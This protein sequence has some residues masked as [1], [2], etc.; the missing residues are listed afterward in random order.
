MPDIRSFFGGG[1][2]VSKA[3]DSPAKGKKSP[4]PA[5]KK[6]KRRSGSPGRSPAGGAKRQRCSDGAATKS[7]SENKQSADNDASARE[8]YVWE[9]ESTSGFNAFTAKHSEAIERT[10]SAG[11]KK[12]KLE[13]A[14][15]DR[16]VVNVKR[17]RRIVLSTGEATSVRRIPQSQSVQSGAG[18]KRR[19]AA[20]VDTSK[21]SLGAF[22]FEAAPEPEPKKRRAWNPTWSKGGSGARPELAGIKPKPKPRP[23]CFLKKDDKGKAKPLTFV[24]TGVLES[25]ERGAMKALIE[26]CGGRVTGSV[27]GRTNYLVSGKMLEDGRACT[28]GSKWKKAKGKHADTCKVVDETGVFTLIDPKYDPTAEVEDAYVPP[29][30]NTLDN[31]GA[32]ESASKAGPAAPRGGASA[33][34]SSG[35]SVTHSKAVTRRSSDG[36]LWSVKHRPR[37]PRDLVGNDDTIARMTKWLERWTLKG[38]GTKGR[39]VLISGPPGIGKTSAAKLVA[40]HCGF[41]PLEFNASDK[42]NARAM[43]ELVET[44]NSRSIGGSFAASSGGPPRRRVLIMDEVDGMGGGDRGGAAELAGV[45]KECRSPVICICNDPTNKKMSAIKRVAMELP[46]RRPST[47]A[48]ARRMQIVARREGLEVGMPALRILV[49]SSGNDIRQVINALQM[50]SRSA[51]KLSEGRWEAPAGVYQLFFSRASVSSRFLVT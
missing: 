21:D 51:S 18:R 7:P 37:E 32:S 25:L 27:S 6:K 16:I 4:G 39:A 14:S 3:E 42:R 43:K 40:E 49:E 23:G 8:T 45:I 12:I 30:P 44:V 41:E 34:A 9:F 11:E 2:G 24:I 15:G 10:F 38:V 26:A 1:G 13:L 35:K 36:Q 46:F 19:A 50:H 48:I 47:E 17:M 28:E 31:C 5:R 20:A 33:S 22:D 29:D